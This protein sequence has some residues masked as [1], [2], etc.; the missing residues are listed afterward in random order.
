MASRIN[1]DS[2]NGLQ[3]VSDSSGEIQIQSSGV[4]VATANSSGV[5]VTGNLSVSGRV[6]VSTPVSLY[7]YLPSL[8]SIPNTTVTIVPF[9]S[10]GYQYGGSNF[11]TS[12]YIYTIP[13]SGIYSVILNNEMNAANEIH[14][15]IF[16]NGSSNAAKGLADVWVQTGNT[17]TTVANHSITKSTIL[18]LV[19]GDTLSFYVYHSSGGARNLI[20]NRTYVNIHLLG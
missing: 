2:S 8:I 13:V 10:I 11:N 9:T 18:N 6:Q 17:V 14:A 16:I 4:T 7:A 20:G 1:A 15:G 19:A 12:T 5:N 3:L